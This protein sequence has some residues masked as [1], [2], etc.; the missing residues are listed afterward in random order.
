M[1]VFHA[2]N[3]FADQTL[4]FVR[5]RVWLA[6]I[7]VI[8]V[9]VAGNTAEARRYGAIVIDAETGQVIHAENADRQAYPASLTKM[10]TLYLTFEALDLGKLKLHQK[11]PVSRRA[12]G[13]APSKLGLRRGQSITVQDAIMAL[14]TK[15]ANDAA[16][17]VAEAIGGTESEFA[18]LM[19]NKARALGMNSTTFRNA[20]GLPNKGQLTTARDMARLAQALQRHFPEYYKLFSTRSFSYKG[21]S[22]PNH[23]RLLRTYKGTDGVKTGYTHASGYNLVASVVRGD[24]RL[25]AVVFGGKTSRSRDKHM[26]KLLDRG[27]AEVR[28]ARRIDPLPEGPARRPGDSA[29]VQLAGLPAPTPFPSPAAAMAAEETLTGGALADPSATAQANGATT[30]TAAELGLQPH[31]KQ[32][33]AVPLFVADAPVPMPPQF[34]AIPERS[35]VDSAEGSADSPV[36]TPPSYEL[37]PT[38][39]SDLTFL[40]ENSEG[41]SGG[42]INFQLISTAAAATGA[43][44]VQVGAYHRH[45]PAE[46]AAKDA[47]QRL[48]E[49]LSETEVVVSKIQGKKHMIYRAR[50]MGLDEDTA[51]VAC[52][53]LELINVSCYVVAPSARG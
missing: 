31:V 7:A 9:L 32:Q 17:V 49:F 22:Y 46:R 18:V 19:T 47:I 26:M 3:T 39:P 53:R 12:A 24:R 51:R 20:S 13:M 45:A 14:I 8:F 48:P 10:M 35:D 28:T 2:A 29:E 4:F 34:A 43:W 6:A 42:T 27:F 11:L 50:L 44:G 38:R 21:R 37:I 25:I 15:S 52:G 40:A 30:A 36:P 16:V 41:G 5:G 33:P 23:N 1:F